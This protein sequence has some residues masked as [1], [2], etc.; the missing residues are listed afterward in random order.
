MRSPACRHPGS[1]FVTRGWTSR[2][3]SGS[4]NRWVTASAEAGHYRP[5]TG[6]SGVGIRDEVGWPAR[7]RH[8]ARRSLPL[9]QPQRQRGDPNSFPEL[10]SALL[11]TLRGRDVTLNGETVA[12]GEQ[13]RPSFRWR[14]GRQ[15]TCRA[16]RSAAATRRDALSSRVRR[17]EQG[18]PSRPRTVVAD[19]LHLLASE[20][21]S[22]WSG[23]LLERRRSCRGGVVSAKFRQRPS[24]RYARRA[25]AVQG[26]ADLYG[27]AEGASTRPVSGAGRRGGANGCRP[28][29]QMRCRRVLHR[30]LRRSRP[31]RRAVLP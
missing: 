17:A 25:A 11:D 3:E 13:G 7:D 5:A 8:R 16:R 26:V 31:P 20:L 19:D 18:R 10:V 22:G 4:A 1:R 6:R 2:A 28:H 9:V 29:R 30:C 12:L 21:L 14:P 27:S 24:G 15:R 23:V